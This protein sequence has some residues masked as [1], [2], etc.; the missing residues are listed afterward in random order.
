MLKLK[1]LLRLDEIKYSG[2]K[3]TPNSLSCIKNVCNMV[4]IIN[5]SLLNFFVLRKL[6]NIT[7]EIKKITPKAISGLPIVWI[8][9]N[10][11]FPPPIPKLSKKE[12]KIIAIEE[13]R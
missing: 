6:K 8:L 11:L 1:D 3:N 5:S 7:T 13:F 4:I 10:V 9:I 2:K 12:N